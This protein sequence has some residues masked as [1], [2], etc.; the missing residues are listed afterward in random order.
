MKKF[1]QYL[2]LIILISISGIILTNREPSRVFFQKVRRTYIEKPCTKP[3]KYSI[4]N[5]DSRFNITQA[6]LQNTILQAE[7][8]WEKPIGR[9]LF[10]YDPNSQFK[11]NL[12]YDDRQERTQESAKLENTLGKLESSHE[13]I[14]G[15]YNNLS[16]A[17]KKRLDAY[18]KA[19]ADYEK[20]LKKYNDE[21]D[22]WNKKGGAPPD[23][24]DNLK[25]EKKDLQDTFS[26]LEK[27]RKVVNSLIGQTNNLV[28]QEKNI[29]SNYNS[30]LSSY[31][32]K[33]G[34]P[35]QFDKGVYDGTKIDIFQFNE[36]GDL[37][38]TIAHE[39][40]HALGID[41]LENPQSLM[42]YLMGEQDLSN[43]Q[44]STEDIAALKDV[45][46]TK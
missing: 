30:N 19:A 10:E 42:Y 36:I 14:I 28:E 33:Y 12:V 20:Q 38:L 16:S 31:Q 45:C 34:E 29:V 40:G 21:V 8:I 18:N 26:T 4:G 2:I 39:F 25:K 24:Y 23:V 11:I 3:I 37:R 6:D 32:N 5:V 13:Q 22:S 46:N 44:L 43:P 9:N 7:N 41:H 27:E 17:Y 35:V 1:F 15:Q